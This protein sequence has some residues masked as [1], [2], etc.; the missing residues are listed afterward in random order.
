MTEFTKYDMIACLPQVARR[1][2]L[3]DVSIDG[4]LDK[5]ALAR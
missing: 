3:G 4:L 1:M 2:V 5:R